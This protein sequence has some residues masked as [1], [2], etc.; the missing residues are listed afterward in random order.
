MCEVLQELSLRK[1]FIWGMVSG[2]SSWGVGKW[3]RQG[4]SKRCLIRQVTFVT[5][6][7][8]LWGG[9]RRSVVPAGR[10]GAGACVSPL[11]SLQAV[12]R[13][14]GSLTSSLPC[15]PA[16][17][18]LWVC[19]TILTDAEAVSE[20]PRASTGAS[21]QFLNLCFPIFHMGVT[22]AALFQGFVRIK[23]HNPEKLFQVDEYNS[24][25]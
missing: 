11:R 3:G 10:E 21:G 22:A 1:L 20:A 18:R 8:H 9:E 23:G 17:G 6:R 4:K 25:G 16:Q 15:P 7:A 12:P 13:R 19:R 2:S 5:T 14:T 24:I